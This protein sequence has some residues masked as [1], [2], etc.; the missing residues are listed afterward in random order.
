MD[1]IE[2]R[3]ELMG[4]NLDLIKTGGQGPLAWSAYWD[5]LRFEQEQGWEAMLVCLYVR[6]CVRGERE[7]GVVIVCLC[8]VCVCVCV[9][10]CVRAC[11]CVCVCVGGGGG[12]GGRG[13]ARA[14][15]ENSFQ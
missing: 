9:R 14:L 15:L 1:L 2:T 13:D 10:A 3:S 4:G 6:E 11:V 8:R 7:E 12:G 5:R